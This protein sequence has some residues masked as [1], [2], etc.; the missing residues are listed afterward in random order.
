LLVVLAIIAVL[1][2]LLLPAVQSARESASRLQCQN[3]LHQIGIAL[4]SYHD[5]E[6]TFP[7]GYWSAV[8]AEDSD[9]GPGWGWA[10]FLLNDLEQGNLQHG[11]NF[12]FGI[13]GQAGVQ[14]LSIYLCPS[15]TLPLT[16]IIAKANVELAS[17][18]YVAVFGEPRIVIDPGGGDG[19]FYRNSRTRIL[20]IT[21]G[22][23]STLMI[24]E[25]SGR[26]AY[27]SWPGALVGSE[28]TPN[29]P[30]TWGVGTPPVLCLGRVGWGSTTDNHAPNNATNSVEDFSSRHPGGA[31]FVFADGSAHFIL[32]SIDPVVYAALGTRAGGEPVS[33][34]DF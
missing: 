2:A 21:D 4:Q 22:T 7:P 23:S 5:R 18:N 16:F 1:L 12:S 31:N 19:I 28:V 30:T 11:I 6:L 26:V 14:G 32:N 27:S 10:A 20:D 8:D 17:S 25:R 13:G 3:N 34:G 29:S 9:I 15:D 24:G 33:A